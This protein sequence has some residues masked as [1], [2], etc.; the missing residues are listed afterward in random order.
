[1]VANV[2]VGTADYVRYGAHNG[3]WPIGASGWVSVRRGPGEE[4]QRPQCEFAA[5][6]HVTDASVAVALRLCADETPATWAALLR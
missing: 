1:V 2:V 5:S 4:H 6:P 3:F